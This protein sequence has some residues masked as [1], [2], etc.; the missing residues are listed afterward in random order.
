MGHKPKEREEEKEIQKTTDY[1]P[2]TNHYSPASTSLRQ[3][4]LNQCKHLHQPALVPISD[5]RQ[6][7]IRLT[8]ILF[9][10]VTDH[11][12]SRIEDG[13]AFAS[14][15]LLCPIHHMGLNQILAISGPETFF[16][17]FRTNFACSNWYQ[18]LKY[19]EPS[20]FTNSYWLSGRIW[21]HMHP[22][23]AF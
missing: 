16:D 13:R 2:K 4:P 17:E 21:T 14:Q 6:R 19:L 23:M 12:S 5:S 9:M 22:W 10:I 11:Y 18:I 15:F 3:L 20:F 7:Y 8:A 1:R